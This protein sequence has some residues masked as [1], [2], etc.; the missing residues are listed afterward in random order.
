MKAGRK[1]ILY[2]PHLMPW[3]RG[4]FCFVVIDLKA[5]EAGMPVL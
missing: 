2:V 3:E 4:T 5:H 1:N